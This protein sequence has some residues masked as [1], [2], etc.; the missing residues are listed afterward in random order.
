MNND[1]VTVSLLGWNVYKMIKSCQ[2]LASHHPNVFWMDQVPNSV[3]IIVN[4]TTC[5]FDI[6]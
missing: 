5:K 3:L 1:V 2:L 6:N 4:V